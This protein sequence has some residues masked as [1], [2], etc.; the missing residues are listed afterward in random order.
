MGGHLYTGYHK[1]GNEIVV[2]LPDFG[3]CHALSE[4]INSVVIVSETANLDTYTGAFAYGGLRQTD[5]TPPQPSFRVTP[6]TG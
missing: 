2:D 1:S 4:P 3:T 6:L 5:V